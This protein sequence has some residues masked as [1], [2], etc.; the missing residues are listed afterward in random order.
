MMQMKESEYMADYFLRFLALTA[1]MKSSG[2]TLLEQVMIEKVLCTFTPQ[3]DL[4]V[5]TIDENDNLIKMKME[6]LQGTLEPRELIVNQREGEKDVKH[7][8]LAQTM[9]TTFE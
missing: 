4:I 6:E 1:Q 8:L 5:V 3:Y 9:K 7:A 2:K